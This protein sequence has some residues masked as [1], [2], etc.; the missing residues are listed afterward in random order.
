MLVIDD[1][2]MKGSFEVNDK[3]STISKLSIIKRK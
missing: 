3:V 1:E 2:N